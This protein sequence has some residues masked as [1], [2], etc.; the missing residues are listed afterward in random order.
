MK[1]RKVLQFISFFI[2]AVS[3]FSYTEELN[4]LK[5]RL[6]YFSDELFLNEDQK[7]KLFEILKAEDIEVKNPAI[8]Y[9]ILNDPF[10]KIVKIEK[11]KFNR[12]SIELKSFLSKTQFDKYLVLKNA[13]S[14]NKL[15]LYLSNELELTTSQFF[16]ID[17]IGKITI[18]KL[19]V[20][21]DSLAGGSMYTYESDKT[22]NGSQ[23]NT[24]NNGGRD[25]DHVL[26]VFD[27][28]LSGS[29]A[30]DYQRKVYEIKHGNIMKYL[31]KDIAGFS[32]EKD[33]KGGR[34]NVPGGRGGGAGQGGGRPGGR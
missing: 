1:R 34:G 14:K 15:S 32:L 9:D 13:S 33:E 26:A 24:V 27:R 6:N 18:R 7:N 8:T 22:K 11:D 10:D 3:F 20:I 12:K 25:V 16:Y 4:L 21:K 29:I 5:I 28:E 17:A 23:S 31:M 2:F 19:N 30:D